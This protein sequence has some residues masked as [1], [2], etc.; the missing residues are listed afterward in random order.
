MGLPADETFCVPDDVRRALPGGRGP[1]P[2]RAGGVGQA[3]RRL[4]PA[5]APPRRLPGRRRACPAGPTRCPPGPR[6][7]RRS[8]PA[9]P[10]ARCLQALADVVP[11]LVAGGADLT[12]N[13]GTVLQGHGVLVGRRARRPPALLRHPRAR[14]GRHHDRHGRCTAASC[15]SAAPSWCSATTAAPRSAWPRCR[16]AKVIYSFTHDSVGV[17]ED[18]PTHQP[19][20]HVA[21]LRAIP[22]L[23]VIRPADA[24]ETAAAWRLAVEHDGPTALILSRQDLPVLDGTAEADRR[25][26]APTCCVPADDPDVVLV[27]HG[28]RGRRVRG[29]RRR[30]STAE[31]CAPRWCRC[32]AGSCSREQPDAYQDRVLP[33]E[34]PTLAVEAGATLGWERWADDALGI[35]RFGASAPGRRVLERARL[36]PGARGGAGPPARRRPGG[37]RMTATDRLHELHEPRARA[38]GSTTCGGAGSPAASWP[39]GSTAASGASPRTRRSSRRRSAAAPTTTSSSATWS[40]AAASV[41]DAYWDLVV[42]DIEGALR[43]LRPVYDDSD[44]V[45]GFV[46]VEVA[47]DLARDTAGT[48]RRGPRTS[49]S[50]STSPTCY[51][52]IPGTAEG[53]DPIRTMIAEGRSI[54]VTLIFS[55][56][57]YA[58]VMEAYLSGLEAAEGDLSRIASVASF[59]ISPGRHRGRPSARR[60]RHRRGPGAAG[61][62]RRGPG[63]GRLPA[64]PRDLPRARGGTRSSPA[65]PACSGRCGRRRRPRTPSYPD[66]L[67]VDELIGPDTVN[68]M[69]EDTIEAFVD[70]GTVART[71]DAVAR[72]RPGRPRRRDRG[73]RRPRRRRPG[74]GGARG[75]GVRQ[76]LRRAAS[77]PSTPRPSSSGRRSSRRCTASWSSSTT[78]PGEFAERV[79][80]A[81]HTR[82]NDGFSL[83]VSGGETAR[84]ALPAPGRRRR[85]ADRLVEGRRLLGRRA[86]RPPRLPESNYH[87]VRDLAPRAG[88]RRERQLPDVLRRGPRPLPAPA[89]RAGP[90][91]RRPPRPRPRRPHRLAVPRLD[92]PR[93]RSR[94]GWW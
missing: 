73:G 32:R 57:R 36:H 9:W 84:A 17:G 40:G 86:L 10:A 7:T 30:C 90:L 28:Q 50:G 49:T 78:W 82:P 43:L 81:F 63:P 26:R 20:E 89:G 21:S 27:A 47:P 85:H 91:R 58:E 31:G 19:I 24:N 42:T 64:L 88:R 15:P 75:G 65:A 23:R 74:A 92:R 59:F 29:R 83:A 62:G 22:G 12:S 61:Q 93:G 25:P 80:E 6:A 70:H 11:G 45:D 2:R 72:R 68:T 94:A 76:V 33:P 48:D 1:G 44:G 53:L 67:Y 3:P 52:K 39:A 69:P 37:V 34:V 79:I 46:S 4:R 16:G 18:G 60:D 55:L 38:R 8:P 77:T 13:T 71:V 35:D 54:N 66:T 87:L 14:D 56:D 5:T 51:V 41:E